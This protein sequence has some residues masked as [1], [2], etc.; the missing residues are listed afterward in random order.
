MSYIY[1]SRQFYT[2]TTAAAAEPLSLTDAKL[3]LRV[4][5]SDEDS[6]I[7]ACITASR[8]YVEARINRVLVTSTLTLTQDRF[9]C[10]SGVIEI[11]RCPVQTVTS[12]QYVDTDG[13]TQT[14]SASLYTLD[15]TSEPARLVPAYTQW[16]PTTRG[17]IHD[18]TVTFT[19]GYGAASA[20]PEGIK[21]AMRLLVQQFYDQRA[22][23][24]IG[25]AVNEFN[26]SGTSVVE[27]LLNQFRWEI[28]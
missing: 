18:V 28:H 2:V 16:W 27:S 4:D 22:P 10:L 7:G 6:L 24:A 20:V 19:A 15:A 11:N 1:P 25:G 5:H 21:S 3:H 26:F 9:P 12:V 17:H 13:V 23:I 14:L 8:Q